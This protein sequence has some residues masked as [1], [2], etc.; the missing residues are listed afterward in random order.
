MDGMS[1]L[2]CI[3]KH[4]SKYIRTLYLLLRIVSITIPPWIEFLSRSSGITENKFQQT[5]S[6]LRA[7]LKARL[8]WLLVGGAMS[9]SLCDCGGVDRNGAIMDARFFFLPL[10]M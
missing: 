4:V 1:G 5:F 3:G 9:F 10:W 7:R 6:F 8:C 2:L